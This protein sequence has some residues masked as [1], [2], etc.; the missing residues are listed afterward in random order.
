VHEGKKKDFLLTTVAR[1]GMSC[2]DNVQL[3]ANY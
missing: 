1:S 3:A 2:L